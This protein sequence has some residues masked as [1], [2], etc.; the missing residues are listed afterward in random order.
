MYW[1]LGTYR[2]NITMSSSWGRLLFTCHV[3]FRP[4]ITFP[5]S[6]DSDVVVQW[7]FRVV[8]SPV[9]WLGKSEIPHLDGVTSHEPISPSLLSEFLSGYLATLRIDW[10]HLMPDDLRI[11][12]PLESSWKN[13]E[14][15]WVFW[16]IGVNGM[17]IQRLPLR[18]LSI[19]FDLPSKPSIST[20]WFKS[21]DLLLIFLSTLP[22]PLLLICKNIRCH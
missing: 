1:V 5:L 19:S 12:G 22:Q 17:P 6:I 16:S 21:Q 9:T 3:S 20:I 10:I 4:T 11:E 7:V 13:R 14:M 8:A 18:S 2:K 15:W